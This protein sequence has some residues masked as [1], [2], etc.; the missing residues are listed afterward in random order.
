MADQKGY[1]D[2]GGPSLLD[3]LMSSMGYN[4]S[5]QKDGIYGYYDPTNPRSAS[6]GM[7]FG[8]YQA[9]KQK[10]AP[11]KAERQ[12]LIPQLLSKGYT[13]QDMGIFDQ[14]DYGKSLFN[15]F[16][17]QNAQVAAGR[18]N[19]TI[20]NPTIPQVMNPSAAA[21]KPHSAPAPNAPGATSQTQTPSTPA[22][23]STQPVNNSQ[24]L[25]YTSQ[26][27][28]QTEGV[29]QSQDKRVIPGKMQ[30]KSPIRFRGIFS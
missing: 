25:G 5:D 11:I 15:E 13:L 8:E 27:A 24:P 7:S 18:A 21:S 16:R 3:D 14:S 29:G 28:P 17:S 1:G 23:A 12:A 20:P 2:F 30:D 26:Q 9:N 4:L 6:Y 19:G 10:V 22:Q